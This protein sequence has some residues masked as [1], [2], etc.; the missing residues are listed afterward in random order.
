MEKSDQNPP[1]LPRQPS[2]MTFFLVAL[3]LFVVGWGGLALVTYYTLPTLGPRWLFFFLVVLA[4]TGTFLPVIAFLNRRFPN[5]PPVGGEVIM[6][7][8][9]WFGIYA[10]LITWLQMGRVLTPVLAVILFAAFILV[11]G[12]LRL[13]ERSRWRPN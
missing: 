9:L 5:T 6:R 11:E 8:A 4:L 2:F 12:L 13:F 1:E 7:Q 3:L 10:S